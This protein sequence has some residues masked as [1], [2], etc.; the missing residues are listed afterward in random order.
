MGKGKKAWPYLPIEVLSFRDREDYSRM[1]DVFN[2]LSEESPANRSLHRRL[3]ERSDG[4]MGESLVEDLKWRCEHLGMTH[5]FWDLVYSTVP[6]HLTQI[7]TQETTGGPKDV[8]DPNTAGNIYQ[9]LWSH[10]SYN[11][12]HL[13]SY[14]AWN[15]HRP[16][17]KS[18]DCRSCVHYPRR[19]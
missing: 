8:V 5:R 17:G 16:D 1:R 11:N 2:I 14:M 18:L 15:Y 3:N 12:G 19:L 13:V 9:T 6:Y 4:T 7:A 10:G